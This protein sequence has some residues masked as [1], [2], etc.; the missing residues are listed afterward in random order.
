MKRLLV[1]GALLAVLPLPL[2]LLL[3]PIAVLAVTLAPSPTALADI[4]G[5]LL[6]VYQE[7]AA[8]CGLSWTVLAAV[9]K[10]ETDHARS[11][12]PGV[13][14]GANAAGAAGPMQIGI[15]GRAG[16]T[17]G[18]DP[19]RSVPPH[20]PY[21]TDG[22]GDGVAD[23]YDPVDA[24]H[25][26]AVY[27]CDHGA[28]DSARLRDAIWA[29]NHAD[30]YVDLVLEV[31]AGYADLAAEA[32]ASVAAGEGPQR[33]SGPGVDGQPGTFEDYVTALA[34]QVEAA[35]RQLDA[36][37]GGGLRIRS[38]TRTA[39]YQARLCP[40]VAGPCAP[41]GRSMHQYGLAIDTP[42]YVRAAAVLRAHPEIPLCQP[43]P[44]TDANHLSHHD[45]TEC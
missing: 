40:K 35:V 31:A 24:I 21:G 45:G 9:G 44:D 3:L 23:V 22:N 18:G 34:P 4:P 42:D 2:G 25:S 29:Y 7:A 36:A 41:P 30:W 33:T 1:T 6:P 28:G 10:V 20:L 14:R 26:A 13:Q 38:G 17:W 19:V 11:T 32:S 27:L 15:R 5:T 12:L 16:N 39:A 37:M 8:R 43:M